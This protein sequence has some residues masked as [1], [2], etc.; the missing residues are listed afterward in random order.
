MSS[1]KSLNY[2]IPV[3]LLIL[4]GMIYV[5]SLRA[6]NAFVS[7]ILIGVAVVTIVYLTGVIKKMVH[8]LTA[9]KLYKFQSSAEILSEWHAEIRSE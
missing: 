5:M 6:D 7:F 8:F 1:E 4:F 2:I 9:D 3:A